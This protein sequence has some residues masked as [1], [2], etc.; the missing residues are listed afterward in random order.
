[1]ATVT[2]LLCVWSTHLLEAVGFR[3]LPADHNGALEN[4][5]VFALEFDAV[6]DLSYLVLGERLGFCREEG[7]GG[8]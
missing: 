1:M 3:A 7:G 6:A 2:L 5:A 8:C 4:E